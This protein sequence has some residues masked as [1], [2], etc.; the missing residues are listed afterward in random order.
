MNNPRRQTFTIELQPRLVR[1]L[2]DEVTA[3]SWAPYLLSEYVATDLRKHLDGLVADAERQGRATQTKQVHSS[4]AIPQRWSLLPLLVRKRRGHWD[5]RC[6]QQAA[7]LLHKSM[8]VA[9]CSVRVCSART[10]FSLA[11]LLWRAMRTR[12]FGDFLVSSASSQL[13]GTLP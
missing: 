6:Q 2:K 8:V 3:A 11:A 7:S 10:T 1:G 4:Y 9:K 13:R 12:V 5:V